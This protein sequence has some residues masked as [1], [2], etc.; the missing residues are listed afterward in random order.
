MIGKISINNMKRFPSNNAPTISHN[1]NLSFDIGTSHIY[2]TDTDATL[3]EDVND[4]VDTHTQNDTHEPVD[5]DV[6]DRLEASQ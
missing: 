6:K 3:F 2:A 1:V 4:G 5:K